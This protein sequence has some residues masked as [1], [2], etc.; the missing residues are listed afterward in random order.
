[1]AFHS[2]WINT[3]NEET[4]RLESDG[5]VHEVLV[6]GVVQMDIRRQAIHGKE[7]NGDVE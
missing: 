4:S 7:R 6:E 2:E 3:E 1:M 5:E